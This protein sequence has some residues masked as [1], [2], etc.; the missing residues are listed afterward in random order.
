MRTCLQTKTLLVKHGEHSSIANCLTKLPAI[1]PSALR[2]SR[3][4]PKFLL[5]YFTI[6]HGTPND[7]L[8]NP[9]W[10]TLSEAYTEHQSNTAREK[11]S[12]EEKL[13]YCQSLHHKSHMTVTAHM[14]F[15]TG[16]WLP[17]Q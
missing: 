14:R 10:E 5:I 6:S 12:T 17:G 4:I 7:V 15:Y 9:G 8:P 2:I 16:C 11:L 3:G 13:P 1:F